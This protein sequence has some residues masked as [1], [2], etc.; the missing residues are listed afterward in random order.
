MSLF[1]LEL[2][3]KRREFL[4]NR[5]SMHERVVLIWFRETLLSLFFY[6]MLAGLWITVNLIKIV[7]IFDFFFDVDGR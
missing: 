6:N 4:L 5:P 7:S 1:P 3:K 2:K